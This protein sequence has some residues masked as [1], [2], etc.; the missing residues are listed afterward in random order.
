MK[1]KKPIIF[2]IVLF[3]AICL[4]FYPKS[5]IEGAI[6]G[7]NICYSVIIPSLF[8]FM[9]CTLMIFETKTL[10]KLTKKANNLTALLFSLNDCEFT[11]FLLSL[12][13]GYPVGAKLIERLYLEKKVSKDK[14][15]T[16]LSYCVNSGPSFI[17]IAVGSE[18]LNNIKIGYILLASHIIA[19]LSLALF[20][21]KSSKTNFTSQ[22]E[23]KKE[24]YFSESLISSTYEACNSIISI[25]SFVIL[26]S[27]L[28]GLLSSFINN[29]KYKQL[30]LSVLE[31]TNGIAY[32]TKNI[33]FISFLLGFA[34][35]CVHFQVLSSCKK[36]KINYIKFLFFRVVHGGISSLITFI[37]LKIFKIS[38]QT[39]FINNSLSLIPSHNTILFSLLFIAL[40]LLFIVSTK[41]TFKTI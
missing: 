8:P 36:I 30:V 15:E 39:S 24:Y 41:K 1:S 34:G 9:V 6:K 37:L 14:A 27:C 5:A 29:F 38:L 13:G 23:I 21:K 3:F 12:I 31:I 40:S 25:C 18:I 33:Y 20:R 2:I 4:L 26:F 17:V 32:S 11:V 19:S 22:K 7:L 35:F 28:L 10:E 16:M